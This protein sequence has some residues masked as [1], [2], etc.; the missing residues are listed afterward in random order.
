VKHCVIVLLAAAGTAGAQEVK[1]S[2]REGI[3]S[4]TDH[5]QV[6]RSLAAVDAAWSGIHLSVKE[7]VDVV[8]SASLDVRSSAALDAVSSASARAA[9]MSDNR[10]ETVVGASYDDGR[11]HVA[12]LSA[13]YATERDYTS[14]GAGVTG[15][16]DLAA[17]NF[18]LL[19]GG[20]VNHNEVWSIIDPAFQGTLDEIGYSLGVAQV[21]STSDVIRLRYDG[22]YGSGYQA[23][24]YRTVRF[25]DWFV[26]SG[27][28][29][30]LTFSNTIGSAA[31]MPE[32]VPTVRVRHA[33]VLEWVHGFGAGVALLTQARVARDSWG[34]LGGTFG[35]DLRVAGDPWQLRAAYHFYIQGPADFFADKY[36]MAPE[37]YTYYTS[38][39]ELGAE[40][41]HIGSLDLGLALRDW[42]S[43]GR[44]SAI[45]LQLDVLRYDYP[46]FALLPSR[47]SVFVELGLR[48]DF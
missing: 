46:G 17:R 31:G 8:S 4:D 10:F 39:K 45:D 3:Y 29:G 21:L 20:H 12:G 19:G 34:V 30:L 6:I 38:D 5:T 11:G 48:L 16:W 9:G 35:A 18:T 25:G 41:G 15:S 13:V 27:R 23:S 14:L 1:G 47:T 36:T 24:P 33:G 26:A 40:R 2:L 32:K 22:S 42:P 37:S 7:S 43:E 44:A 28:G